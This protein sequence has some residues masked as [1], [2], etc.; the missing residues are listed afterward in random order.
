MSPHP[1]RPEPGDPQHAQEHDPTGVR[2]LLG[3]LPDPGPMPDHLVERITARL[4]VEREHR[5]SA[6]PG[7]TL[8]APADRV[9][10]LAEERGRR[11]PGR[12]LGILTAAAAGLAV[13]TVALT[14]VLGGGASSD[15][16]AVAQYPSRA[17][18]GAGQDEAADA[19]DEQEQGA[20]GGLA[21]SGR[22]GSDTGEAAGGDSDLAGAD[23]LLVEPVVPTLLSPLGEIP[24][25]DYA[26]AVH[27][28]SQSAEAAGSSGAAPGAAGGLTQAGAIQCWATLDEDAQQSWADRFATTATLLGES[29]TTRDVVLLLGVDGESGRAWAVPAECLTTPDVAPVD[30]S[31]ELVEGP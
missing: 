27:G 14:Q 7:H 3:A 8:T 15:S 2:D 19:A 1:P 11:R 29:G 12:T 21:E 30:S 28:A 18:S 6:G 4:E 17:E 22:E 20:S 16:G 31:G 23:D 5:Q 10:D 9:V 25:T 24:A 13:T 26:Q